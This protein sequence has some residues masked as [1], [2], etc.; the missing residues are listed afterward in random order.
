MVVQRPQEPEAIEGRH[1]ILFDGV[2]GLCDHLVQFVL[3]RDRRALFRFAAL[4]SRVGREAVAQACSD[5]SVLTT[6]YVVADFQSGDRRTLTKSE[7]ALFVADQLGWPW[8][9]ALAAR[10]VTRPVLDRVYDLVACLR[11]RAFGRF[12]HCMVPAPEF[13]QRFL[14]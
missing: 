6:M 2:C 1:L 3:K 8:R 7:A 12:E 11:Y 4:Q 10:V 14:E 9:L 13:R 5:P